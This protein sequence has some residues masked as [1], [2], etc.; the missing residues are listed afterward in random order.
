MGL[1]VNAHWV[2]EQLALGEVIPLDATLPPVGVAP[3]V[4][5]RA[6]YA[7]KHLPGAVFFDIDALSDT[8][9]TLPHM[10]PPA[11]RFERE[12]SALGVP[13]SGPDQDGKTLVVY[14]QA[15]VF[16]APRAW[17]MLRVMG[18]ADVRVLDGGLAAWEAAGLPVESGE[19]ALKPAKFDAVLDRTA[20]AGLAELKT[21]LERGE[22]VVDARSPERF[23]G[24]APEPRPGIE[25][26]H[27][28]GATNV[29][30]TELVSEGR[31][32]PSAEIASVFQARGVDL[33][34]P[35][36]TTCGSGVTAA[37]LAL[38]LELCGAE[39]V[40]L[41]DGSWAEYASQPGAAVV[42]S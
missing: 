21:A 8:G 38:G 13:S 35:V 18:A 15:G 2:A 30:Y 11:D 29:P 34:R 12:M 6:R 20:L 28:P 9:T 19:V 3:R 7:A 41:Y 17:W 5:T 27:M 39:R 22:H 16:S 31:L 4:D 23:A 33:R 10:L 36:T 24:T 25:S 42:K 14:E 32:R 37:V 1:L 40:R 26:G